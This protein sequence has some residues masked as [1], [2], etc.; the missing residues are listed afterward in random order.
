MRAK[1][2]LLWCY[3]WAMCWLISS[4]LVSIFGVFRKDGEFTRTFNRFAGYLG[5]SY[6]RDFAEYRE[7]HL[8]EE[9]G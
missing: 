4:P 7:Y 1:I 8:R 9:K 5:F 3:E 6:F 2:L